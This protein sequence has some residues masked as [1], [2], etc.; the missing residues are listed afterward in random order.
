M[1]YFKQLGILSVL[2]SALLF[3]NSVFAQVVGLSDPSRDGNTI[4]FT[5]NLPSIQNNPI[6]N[7]QILIEGTN[8][9]TGPLEVMGFTEDNDCSIGTSLP[10]RNFG[11]LICTRDRQT[12]GV[13]FKVNDS[14][15]EDLTITLV[16]FNSIIYGNEYSTE[17]I[18]NTIPLNNRVLS[19][20]PSIASAP[21]SS[22]PTVN[23]RVF[24]EGILNDE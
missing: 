11:Y 21:A 9:M 24:L 3:T 14:I 16:A 2:M 19:S 18:E 10:L 1:G 8:L 22:N 5:I 4:R 23:V 20:F 15:P 17:N 13:E 12:V 7:A 6:A